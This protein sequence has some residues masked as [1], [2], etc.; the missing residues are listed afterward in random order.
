MLLCLFA[1][2]LAAERKP[3]AQDTPQKPN[4]V[5]ILTDD[6]SKR[7]LRYMP[8]T[9]KLL[10]DQ[11]ASFDNAF[12]T[13]S[14]CCP[15]RATYL[16]GRYAHNHGIKGNFYPEGGHER[17]KEL[18]LDESTTATWLKA[19]GYRT[20]YV[21]KYFN[22]YDTLY[23]PPGWDY[24]R[25]RMESDISNKTLNEDGAIV[26]YPNG[27]FDNIFTRKAVSFVRDSAQ[28][29]FL[30]VGTHAPHGPNDVERKYDGKFSGLKAPRTP[31]YNEKDV[32]DK[33][34]DI[35]R[36]APLKP[37]QIANIDKD[38]RE[39]L[40]A[41]QSVD[42]MV[43]AIVTTLRDTEKLSNTYILFS[44]DNGY[45]FGNHRLTVGKW[46]P[47]EEDI[48]VPLVVRGPSVPEGVR[49]EQFVL[50]NDIAPTFADI[51][52][53][54]PQTEVDGRSLKPL[55]S[56]TP[57]TTWRSAFLVE[58]W[59]STSASGKPSPPE[60]H[61]VRTLNHF[62]AEYPATDET[63]FYKMAKD[64]YQLES[65]HDTQNTVVL[66]ELKAR[67]DALKRCAGETCRAA[68]GN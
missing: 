5:F 27:N 58:N 36:R 2:M 1:G 3:L 52:G 48:R 44:S 56:G 46:R 28:P 10:V 8:R 49:R 26:Q 61:A 37:S 15:S 19:A 14:L 66:G 32:S 57:P 68:E 39:R 60:Y 25:T 7:D 51:A 6:M 55:F 64:P 45:H 33:P 23:V 54:Q 31:N 29:F 38:Y 40:E 41:L 67:L 21:G 12:V 22:E 53:A 13:Y 63:E 47:Y 9:N 24:W 65:R 62:Y 35:R 4:I 18:G 50:N 20:G 43:A 16:T 34:S 11:G 30:Q 42:E 59:V 17:F